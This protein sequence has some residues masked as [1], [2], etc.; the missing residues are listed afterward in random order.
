M[1]SGHR[2]LQAGKL[3]ASRTLGGVG[4]SL[5]VASALQPTLNSFMGMGKAAWYETRSTVMRLLSS[6]EG[7]LRD[8]A[9]L[10]Q[11]ALLS[12]VPALQQRDGCQ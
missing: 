9:Q 2:L 7:R 8:D 11:E 6:S 3:P 12:Q 4:K 10:R 1:P 5:L